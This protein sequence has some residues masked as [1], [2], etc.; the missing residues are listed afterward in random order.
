MKI[1]SLQTLAMLAHE[2]RHDYRIVL[3]NGCFDLPHAGHIK[4]LEAAKKLGDILM[5]T[6]T[7]DECVDKGPGRPFFPVKTRC[8]TLA[9]LSC[10]DYVTVNTPIPGEAIRMLRPHIYVKGGE[11]RDVVTT[12]LELERMAIEEVGGELVFTETA[13]HHSTALLMS[14]GV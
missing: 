14:L 3:A 13:E 2:L 10:V 8:E 7:R 9:A 11:Y 1:L 5:V 4:H 12:G 6:V